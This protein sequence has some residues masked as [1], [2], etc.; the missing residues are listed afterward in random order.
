[1][2]Y[3]AMQRLVESGAVPRQR[4]Y[5]K[6]GFLRELG[7]EAMAAI[8]AHICS[9]TKPGPFL[10]IF[11]FNGAVNRVA[12]EASAFAHRHASFDLTIGAKWLDPSEEAAQIG[13]VRACYAA[14][15]PH[16]TGGVYVNYLGNEGAERVRAAYGPNYDRLVALKRKY[17]P[18]N[19]FRLNQNIAP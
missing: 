11:Q 14:L 4:N 13:W 12:P 9:V 19:F 2:P 3:T 7:D 5:W 18:T 16:T 10:E 15:E 8:V 6:A 17:D 1:M